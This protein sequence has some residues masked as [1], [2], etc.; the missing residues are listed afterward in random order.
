[1][2]G[3]RSER[4]LKVTELSNP[5]SSFQQ[6]QSLPLLAGRIRK[7]RPGP[8]L[9]VLSSSL[10]RL[11]IFV[12][13]V[14]CRCLHSLWFFLHTVFVSAGSPWSH[15]SSTVWTS[16]LDQGIIFLVA[17]HCYFEKERNT[18][19]CCCRV[20]KMAAM[21]FLKHGNCRGSYPDHRQGQVQ[22][23]VPVKFLLVTELSD[24]PSSFQQLQ[25]LLRLE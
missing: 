23:S 7:E 12:P 17:V 4:R 24:P 6:L 3:K 25:S 22:R 14:P 1:M 18:P 11:F 20:F 16:L 2:N 15:R 8:G 19:G 13:S 5:L 10:S 9:L 21:K